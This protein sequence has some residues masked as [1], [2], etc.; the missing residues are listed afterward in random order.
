MK[1]ITNIEDLRRL[2]E[3]RVPKM[4]YD[5]ADSGSWTEQTYRENSEDF[6]K[7]KLRQ[8]VATNIS[9]RSTQTKML[10]VSVSLPT[11]LAP[12]GMTGMQRADGEILAA[13]AAEKFN[14]PFTMST[15]SICSIEDV[16]K[17]VNA[18]FWF[19]LYVM[20]DKKYSENLIN[21][22]K[23]AGCSALML[24]L[25]LQLMGQ[26]HKDIKNGL[27]APPKI[28]SVNTLINLA[29]RPKW[30]FEMLQTRRRSFR[31]V[32]GHVDGVSDL[33][34]LSAWVGEAFDLQFTWDD[35]E[36]IKDLWGGKLILK[37][38]LDEEDAQMAVKSG[39]DA[40]I[41]SNHGGRQLDG[42]SSSISMLSSIA[43]SVGQDIE[44]WVDG[45][46]RSGQD[47]LKSVALG[48]SGTLIGRP[49]L[50]GLGA[51]GG[52]GVTK[53]LEILSKELDLS[54]ALCGHTDINAVTKDIIKSI[55]F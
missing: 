49:Y 4:F 33:S 47:I 31:N 25:D 46:I 18:P 45:G 2:A 38:I 27:S 7:I 43:Q 37:G 14:V 26:R 20:K 23:A 50:Y 17:H 1:I 40:L 52:E 8:R 3:K 35:I 16:A 6:K 12:C 39:A 28:N 41:V 48:A 44:V 29:L 36:R 21:R 34:S 9:N 32:V 22:A 5:Y 13:K 55:N 42:T 11:A 54:M 24:T 10:G 53:C 19:Q 30:C 15:L 51:L